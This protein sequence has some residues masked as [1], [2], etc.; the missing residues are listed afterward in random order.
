MAQE[1]PFDLILTSA[2]DRDRAVKMWRARVVRGL[3]VM[4]EEQLV[5]SLILGSLVVDL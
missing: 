5:Q 4:D 3:R 1:Q 2:V